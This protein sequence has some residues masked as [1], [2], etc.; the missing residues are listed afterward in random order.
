LRWRC[1]C[2]EIRI[3]ELADAARAGFGG[4]TEKD[5]M[6][7]VTSG[8]TLPARSRRPVDGYGGYVFLP[9]KEIERCVEY[10]LEVR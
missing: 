5:A 1:V 8:Q 10:W 7:T 9:L 4:A 3:A 2:A 6:R